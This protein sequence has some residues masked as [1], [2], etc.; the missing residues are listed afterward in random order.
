MRRAAALGLALGAAAACAESAAFDEE[1]YRAMLYELRCMVCQ[2]QSLADSDAE[3]AADLRGRV[4]ALMEQGR[5]DAE[6]IE[7][8]R[9]RYGDFVLYRPPFSWRTAA[10]WLGPFA[11]LLAAAALL[12]RRIRRVHAHRP[13]RLSEQERA[14]L[15]R[16][17]AE[18]ESR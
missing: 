10:L 17:L 12:A 16:M 15:R 9:A 1:R 7:H 13:G 6:I 18:R 3:L 14:R 5:S 4:R 8:L 11:L 2:N